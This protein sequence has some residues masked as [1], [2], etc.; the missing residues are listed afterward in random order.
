[1]AS[2]TEICNTALGRIG[3]KRITNYGDATEDSAQ[4]VLCRLHYD[5]TKKSLIRSYKWPFA[6][7]QSTLARDTVTPDFEYDYQYHMPDDYLSPLGFY[8]G[9]KSNINLDS[10]EIQGRLLLTDETTVELKYIKNVDDVSLFDPLFT[11]VL[12]LRLALKLLPGLGGVANT[13]LVEAIGM[14]LREAESKAR[15]VSA[16]EGNTVGSNDRE[17]WNDA[18][19]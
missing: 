8:E 12:A 4:A 13:A 11:D 17:K 3:S 9:R 15:V 18:R 1:M 2:I 6:I 5:P 7:A 16:Q 10:F 19:Y 14:E